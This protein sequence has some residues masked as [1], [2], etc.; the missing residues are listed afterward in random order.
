M[1]KNGLDITANGSP[2]VY[3]DAVMSDT[4][5]PVNTRWIPPGQWLYFAFPVADCNVLTRIS[6]I[7]Y[8][9]RVVLVS[10]K[11]RYENDATFRKE[12]SSSPM[13]WP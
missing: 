12:V 11:R 1:T 6:A 7:E 2:K 10:G 8:Q 4:A 9:F 3:T 5:R 13:A